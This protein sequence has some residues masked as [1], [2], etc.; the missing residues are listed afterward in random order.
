MFLIRSGLEAAG[1]VGQMDAPEGD[2]CCGCEHED[3][4]RTEELYTA[5]NVED[6]GLACGECYFRHPLAP[7]TAFVTGLRLT[8]VTNS[9]CAGT[10]A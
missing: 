3:C 7:C 9:S 5:L 4:L 2:K 8:S 10:R 6:S 1:G